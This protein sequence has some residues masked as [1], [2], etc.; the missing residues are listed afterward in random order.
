M[1][2]VRWAAQGKKNKKNGGM[3]SSEDADAK[4]KKKKK[5]KGPTTVVEKQR[6]TNLISKAPI[7]RNGQK[8]AG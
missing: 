5:F 6:V 1:R 2:R 8:V 7:C 4:K 3:K